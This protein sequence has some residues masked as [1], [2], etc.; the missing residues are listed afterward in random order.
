MVRGRGAPC[1]GG[2][3]SAPG[4]SR[5]FRGCLPTSTA[6]TPTCFRNL[7]PGESQGQGKQTTNPE[8]CPL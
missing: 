3:G 4:L 2:P 7:R 1:R 8:A 5:P 6:Y